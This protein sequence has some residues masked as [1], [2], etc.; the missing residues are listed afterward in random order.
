M[1]REITEE[2]R[3]QWEEEDKKN[4]E[5][6][7]IRTEYRERV[8][9][10]ADTIHQLIV[11]NQLSVRDA[12]LVLYEAVNRIERFSYITTIE[13]DLVDIHTLVQSNCVPQQFPAERRYRYNVS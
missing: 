6:R 7:R 5:I 4:A 13:D 11:E 3:K 2:Q 9:H 12:K 1:T 10:V 8:I